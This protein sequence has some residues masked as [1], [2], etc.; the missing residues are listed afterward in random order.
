MP[1]AGYNLWLVLIFAT[2][3]NLLGSLT[4]YY[5]GKWGSNFILARFVR[6]DEEKMQRARELFSRW[7]TPILFFSWVP[8]IGDPLTVVGGIMGIR[9]TTFTLWV[10]FGKALR[11]LVILGVIQMLV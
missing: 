11:Y 5:I 8:I 2:S 4:N 6:T 3:G 1:G 9:L 7:G 10:F